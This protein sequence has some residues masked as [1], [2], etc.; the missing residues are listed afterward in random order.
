MRQKELFITFIARICL[1]PESGPLKI[2]FYEKNSTHS[3]VDV[4]FV[5]KNTNVSVMRTLH[6][7]NT[8]LMHPFLIRTTNFCLRLDV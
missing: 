6:Y 3:F 4:H 1:R 8:K 2:A 5:E 7:Y